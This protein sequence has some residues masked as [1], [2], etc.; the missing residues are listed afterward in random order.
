M[1]FYKIQ[2]V[3]R[4]NSP[5]SIQKAL[6]NKRVSKRLSIIRYVVKVGL[7][8][9]SRC[10]QINRTI[11]IGLVIFFEKKIKGNFVPLKVNLVARSKFHPNPWKCIL[12]LSKK[13]RITNY[14]NKLVVWYKENPRR[15]C[16]TESQNN[17]SIIASFESKSK[18]T[19]A[20]GSPP[21]V[22]LSIPNL[23]GTVPSPGVLTGSHVGHYVAQ[24]SAEDRLN[25]A[26]QNRR[27]LWIYSFDIYRVFEF[28]TWTQHAYLVQY[29]VSCA[30]LYALV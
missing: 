29:G 21:L 9:C 20:V 22:I 25:M 12:H 11:Y 5:S 1:V 3:L 28:E 19:A 13:H 6:L 26:T 2:N 23:P 24:S 14:R 8:G 4:R 27:V 16:N 15:H 7:V 18:Q 30:K 17:A 10:K